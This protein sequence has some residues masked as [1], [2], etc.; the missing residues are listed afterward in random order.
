MALDMTPLHEAVLADARQRSGVGPDQVRVVQSEAV[1]WPDGSM[2][3]PA[4]DRMYTQALVP[5]SRLEVEAPGQL[6]LLYHASR[7]GG[8]PGVHAPARRYR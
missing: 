8:W 6:P 1:T 3:C 4:P 2:G 7:R 5:G